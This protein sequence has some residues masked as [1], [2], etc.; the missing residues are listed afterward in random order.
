[1]K[2]F[3]SNNL[4]WFNQDIGID[5]GT[6]KTLI[7]VKGKGVVINEPTVVALNNKTNQILAIGRKAIEMVGKTPPHI[8]AIRPLKNGVISDFEVTEKMIRYFLEKLQS[9][10]FLEN[11][12]KRP[13]LVIGIP[14]GGTEVEKRAVEDVAHS[15]GAREAHLIDEPVAVALG[16]RL[17]I[18]E[19]KG[20]FIVDIGGGTTEAAVISL[21][22]IVVYK[23]LR[24][25]GDKLNDDIIYYLKEKYKMAIGEKTA[26]EIKI[27]IGSALDL[28]SNQEMKIKGR[29][30]TKGLPKEIKIKEADVREAL[31]SSLNKIVDAIQSTLESTPP[32]LISD[33]INDGIYLSGG[34]SLLKGIDKLIANSIGLKTT[35][36]ED[37]ATAVV[38][39]IGFVLEDL[40]EYSDILININREKPPV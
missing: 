8:S 25:A 30:L 35:I 34:S 20:A 31:T 14:C 10:N 7:Y 28:G 27:N 40:K 13:R 2:K 23:S 6:T 26:E 17:P 19:S 4:S 1:M 5:L 18:K 39:G 3:V 16:I 22:G 21:G 38:R 11:L 32:E 9:T 24:V 15:A 37:P 33:I 29:D 12:V 36:V